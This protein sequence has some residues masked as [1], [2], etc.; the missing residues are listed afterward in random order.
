MM[1]QRHRL[2][3]S[4]RP[5]ISTKQHQQRRFSSSSSSTTTTSSFSSSFFRFT[6]WYSRKLDTHPV[7][8]KCISAGLIASLGN[9]LAQRLTHSERSQQ[10][11]DRRRRHDG[12]EGEGG[13]GDDGAPPFVVDVA[14][15]SRFALLNAA[16]VAPVLH[17]WYQFLNRAVPGSSPPRV[18]QRVFWDEF[19][20]SPCYIPVF[21]GL[22][23]KLEGSTNEDIW[24]MTLSDVPT[25]IVAEWVT[26]VPTMALT[27]RYVPVKFQVLVI[28]VV[29]VLWQTFVAYM[30]ANAH[31]RQTSAAEAEALP[32]GGREGGAADV[33]R[34]G[35]GQG[36]G[37]AGSATAPPST[38]D[39]REGSAAGGGIRAAV[40]ERAVPIVLKTLVRHDTPRPME[41]PTT[42]ATR[43]SPPS[44]A[45]PSG[46]PRDT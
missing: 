15:V 25:I 44:H 20:F 11:H 39:D 26:W 32:L 4:G 27:F 28:N 36:D 34:A 1:G 14:Q 16:F 40:E 6:A 3:S 35:G 19:V 21:L 24:R 46:H 42:A 5:R 33:G 10:Q 23:W 17:H 7:T 8:T 41:H 45:T 9:V 29:G 30:A 38:R 37:A 43:I 12:K 22:L 31:A 18:L 13:G 2:P